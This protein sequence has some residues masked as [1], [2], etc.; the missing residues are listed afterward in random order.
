MT[1]FNNGLFPAAAFLILAYTINT[2]L[3]KLTDAVNAMQTAVTAM[4]EVTK[5]YH[6]GVNDGRSE[7]ESAN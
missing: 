1:L 3:E 4:T 7:H 6:G 5:I 2:S